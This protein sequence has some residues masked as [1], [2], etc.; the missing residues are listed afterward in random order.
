M[1]WSRGLGFT[2]EPEARPIES[3]LGLSVLWVGCI[4]AISGH[5]VYGPWIGWQQ[6][7]CD[8]PLVNPVET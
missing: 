5:C 8:A 6:P 3:L 4:L 1:N 2:D 7:R